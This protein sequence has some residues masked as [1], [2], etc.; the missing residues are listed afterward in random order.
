MFEI[1]KTESLADLVTRIQ[2][3]APAIAKKRKAGQ[4]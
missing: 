4:S 1:V 2:F 3:K